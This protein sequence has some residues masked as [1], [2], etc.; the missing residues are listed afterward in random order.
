MRTSLRHSLGPV[1]NLEERLA[2]AVLDFSLISAQSS[3][4]LSG[5]LGGIPIGH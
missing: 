5:N 1:Q 2:P 3:L 4:T